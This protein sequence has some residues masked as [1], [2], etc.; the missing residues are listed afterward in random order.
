MIIETSTH[1]YSPLH[2]ENLKLS[3]VIENFC[4][5]IFEVV[6]KAMKFVKISYSRDQ[7]PK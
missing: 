5:K 6:D 3:N 4:T 2:I 7:F 1:G